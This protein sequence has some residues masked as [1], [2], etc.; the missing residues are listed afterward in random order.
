MLMNN[1]KTI[2]KCSATLAETHN[3]KPFSSTNCDNQIVLDGKLSNGMPLPEKLSV[4]MMFWTHDLQT[5]WSDFWPHL[6]SLWP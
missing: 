3:E 5:S 2:H 6:V 1:T 4:T